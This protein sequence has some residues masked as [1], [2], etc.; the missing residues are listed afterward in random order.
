M[1]S[2]KPDAVIVTAK[3]K[4]LRRGLIALGMVTV[5]VLFTCFGL[6]P[7]I[8]AQAVKHLSAALHREV[9]IEKIRINPF[10]LTLAIEGLLIKD[11]D[12][13]AFTSWKRLFVDLDGFSLFTNEWHVEAIALDGFSQ[14]VAIAKDGTFNFADL[15]RPSAFTD[16]A[17]PAP[18]PV[19]PAKPPRPIRISTLKISGAAF[20]F[21]DASHAQ[22][23]ATTVAPLSFTLQ[24]FV[25]DNDP[26]APYAFS[27]TTE[28]GE[29]LSWKGTVS[30]DPVRSSGEF[31]IGGI[32][33]K[34]YAPYYAALINADLL[35]GVLD[36]NGRYVIDL[37]EGSRQ[38]G[39]TDASIK[40]SRL[41]IA[42]RGST[43]PLIDLPAFVIEGI[44]ADGLKPAATIA[45]IALDGGRL[46]VVREADGSLN[47][48]KLLVVPAAAP[49]APAGAS[50]MPPPA[51]APPRLP[52]VKL[53][54]FAVTGL[55]IDFEDRTTS[56]PVQNGLSRL[57]VSVKNFS[58]TE[59]AVPLVLKLAALTQQGGAIDVA[60]TAVREPLAA[61]LSVNVTALPLA[62][63][64]P[65]IEPLV[66]LRFTGG[67]L[68]VDGRVR[69]ADTVASF[70]GDVTLDKLASVD[71]TKGEDFVTFSQFSIR[72]IHA[73]SAPLA[74]HIDEILLDTP[75]AHLEINADKSTNLSSVLRRETS[76]ASAADVPTPAPAAPT[77]PTS[78]VPTSAPASPPAEAAPVWS[79]AKFTL[80]NG[81]VTVV[82]RSIKPTARLSLD[83]FTGTVSGLSSADLT[84]AD[85]DMRGQINNSGSVTFTGKLDAKAATLTPGALTELFIDV[86][87]VDLSPISPYMGTYAGYELARSGLSLNVKARLTQRTIESTNVVTLNQFTFGPATQSPEATGLPVRLGVAL[88]KDIDGNIVIDLPIRGSL[89]DPEFKIERVVLRV[90]V[91]L[92]M[93][94]TTSP[95]SLIGAAFGGGGDE[96]AYQDFSP[97]VAQP[98]EAELKKTVTLRKA[99]KG[100][101]ALNLDITGSYDAESDQA[102]VRERILTSQVRYRLW[103]EL[104][105]KNPQ[106]PPPSEIVVTPAEEARIIGL[107]LAERAPSAMP[108]LPGPVSKAEPTPVNAKVAATR[109]F[110]YVKGERRVT[111]PAAAAKPVIKAN[112]L[113]PVIAAGQSGVAGAAPLLNLAEARSML[114]AGIVV[115]ADDL[116]QLAQARAQQVRE[117]LLAGGEIDPGRLFLSPPAPEGKG[118]KV[119]LQL[120]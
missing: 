120:R 31:S 40:L 20:A 116:R 26:K 119:F 103:E 94:A 64:T 2:P 41:Q 53:G 98:L 88:L 90:I 67:S 43:T 59:T 65:Y 9:A 97:G 23:F 115:S 12:G 37:A 4:C 82:D 45:R 102:A 104:R 92:L 34:K 52:E 47:L 84:R 73:T 17:A 10:T 36:L 1:S 46:T 87:H 19:A 89:D 6:P 56:T 13:S 32:T 96:L 60:G 114:A 11:R 44:N 112:V 83:H 5:L 91:N 86:Q 71:G 66:N 74:A 63:A 101:P 100:R 7:I 48:L 21:S 110:P 68:S 62:S 72:G 22:P 30:I 27:A 69:L 77:P 54:E 25:T 111:P 70:Q 57:D 79:L 76:P 35:E 93:K 55:A 107:F 61:D 14:R 81:S 99:L 39:L 85:V 58:L 28:A 15:I 3:K 18:A 95:F 75:G 8:R 33:L 109:P 38:L 24:N 50:T 49:A 80:K 118:A 108:P 29:T 78:V 117:A 106:T 105:V 42:A 16:P 51:G 113:T